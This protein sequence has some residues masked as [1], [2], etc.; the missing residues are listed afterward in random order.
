L[1]ERIGRVLSPGV[2]AWTLEV[3]PAGG[4][5]LVGSPGFVA[6]VHDHGVA[7]VRDARIQLA[8]PAEHRAHLRVCSAVSISMRAAFAFGAFCVTVRQGAGARQTSRRRRRR[9]EQPRQ[10]GLA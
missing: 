3:S 8:A 10:S 2:T 5:Y 6:S 7:E 1:R 9:L 4:S